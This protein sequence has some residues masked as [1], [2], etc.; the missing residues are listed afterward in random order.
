MTASLQHNVDRLMKAN[1]FNSNNLSI[2]C[3]IPQPV[4]YRIQKGI[5]TNP[6]VHTLLAI[7]KALHCSI[8]QLLGE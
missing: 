7:A 4:I 2:A 8:D 6:K 5:T 1:G 3:G